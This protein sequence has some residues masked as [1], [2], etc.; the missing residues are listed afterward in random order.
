M[1]F[2][3]INTISGFTTPYSVYACDAY[4]KNCYLVG[5]VSTFPYQLQLPFQFDSA[6]VVGI[7]VVS[8]NAC[9]S[10]SV[11]QFNLFFTPTPTPTSITQTPTPTNK[12]GRAH[13]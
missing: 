10:F 7:R 6:P 1:P 2:V 4:E 13:V 3:T 9:E 12:I 5:S 11:V 8:S